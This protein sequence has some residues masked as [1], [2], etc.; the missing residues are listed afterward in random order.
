MVEAC[1][2][3]ILDV[4]DINSAVTV[5]AKRGDTGRKIII[6]LSN[7]GFPYNIAD[8]CYAVMTAKKPDGNILYN[9]CHINGD[10]IEYEITEQTTAAVGTLLCELKLYGSND[11]LITSAKFRIVVDGTIYSDGRVESESEF[12]SL[13]H[14]VSQANTT[15]SEASDL[16]DDIQKRLDNGEFNGTIISFSYRGAYS[17]TEQYKRSDTISYNGSSYLVLKNCSGVTPAEGEYY[18]LLAKRGDDGSRGPQGKIGPQGPKGPQGNDGPKGEPGP[19]GKSAYQYA[20]EGGYTGTEAEFSA[21]VAYDSRKQIE[22]VKDTMIR[23]H[24]GVTNDASGTVIAL[25]D[26]SSGPLQGLRIY[27]RTTQDGTPTPEA[28]VDLVSVGDGGSVKVTIC[29]KN[30]LNNTA[31]TMEINGVTLTVH[32]DGSITANGTATSDVHF[33]I[34]TVCLQPGEYVLSGCPNGG[35]YN[36]YNIQY[37]FGSNDSGKGLSINVKEGSTK[38]A[39]VR[40]VVFSGVTVDNLKFYPMI[41]PAS[42]TDSTYEPYTGQTLPISTPN[43]LPG[44]P[45][46]SGGNYTDADGQQ[47][48]CDEV[49]F[50]RGVYVQRIGAIDSYAGE[51]VSEPYLSTTG[52]LSTG[53]KVLYVLATPIE[54]PIPE[55]E[56][57]A[58]AAIHTNKPNTTIYNDAGAHMD[59]EYVADT[60]LYIDQKINELATA[61]VSST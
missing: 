59:V 1:S 23:L 42:I 9:H 13:T 20:V 41:R 46:T 52:A 26:A 49:D 54:T 22:T 56:V 29:G 17:Q 11:S 57:A 18:M 32:D 12:S 24:E 60:K 16:V 45:V 37:N 34:G 15:I 35:Y 21:L 39:N 27:G 58:Y 53:A 33:T 19:A 36:T 7:G 47:W 2:R 31:S 50:A 5:Y 8:D 61:I 25:S 30:L 3:V 55:D 43:G 38:N 14:L 10:T 51:A 48:I 44:I 28:P 40:I 6:S 4:Q